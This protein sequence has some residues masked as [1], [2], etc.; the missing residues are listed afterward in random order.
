MKNEQLIKIKAKNFLCLERFHSDFMLFILATE[1]NI[2]FTFKI[3]LYKLYSKKI[4]YTQSDISK[5][6]FSLIFI[7][8]NLIAC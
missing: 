8:T 2:S 7:S 1:W 4:S 5:F 6:A 3:L